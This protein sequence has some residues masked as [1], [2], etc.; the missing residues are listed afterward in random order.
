MSRATI[1]SETQADK[2]IRQGRAIVVGFTA[3]STLVGY[4][5]IVA[6]LVAAEYS[7]ALI[8]L[9]ATL[10]A[11]GVGAVAWGGLR[12][13]RL[14]VSIANNL[15]R[16]RYRLDML[17]ATVELHDAEADL[18]AS[19]GD[20]APAKFPRIVGESR[21]SGAE[22]PSAARSGDDA[23]PGR[24]ADSPSA[25]STENGE[26]QFQTALE[27]GDLRTCRRVWSRLQAGLDEDR[28]AALEEQ[29][30]R[31][32]EEKSRTL[33]E[34]FASLVRNRDF[35]TAMRKGEEIVELFPDS[36]MTVDYKSILPH[37][38]RR[39]RQAESASADA[40]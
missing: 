17:E 7:L 21:K 12:L 15:E 20:S 22:G 23:A 5:F 25:G 30:A 8:G 1:I 2:R 10:A 34:E 18:G 31:L 27:A 13:A 11:C 4:G 14:A 39:E 3:L 26:S 19:S 40:R 33:R 9:V 28:V 16:I 32:K 36:R 29:L 6:K 38:Q 35:K 24:A 37:L